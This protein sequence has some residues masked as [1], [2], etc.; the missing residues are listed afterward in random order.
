[1]TDLDKMRA[2]GT[3]A[4][5]TLD[6]IRPYIVSG[7]TTGE[8]NELCYQFTLDNDAI[9]APLGYKSYPKSVCISVNHV[10]CHGIPGDKKLKNGDILNIDVTPIL[11]GWHGDTSRM[12]HVGKPSIKAN[13]LITATYDAMMY[14]IRVIKPGA[15]IGDIGHAI[16]SSIAKTRFSVVTDYCGHG[17]GKVFH[18]LQQVLNEGVPGEGMVRTEGMYITVEPMV[19]LGKPDT[20]KSSDCWAVVT[21]DKNLSAQWE[22]TIAVVKDGYEI[23]TL[24]ELDI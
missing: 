12:F 19:N 15:T 11:D 7:I 20:N 8:L 9:P 22:H 16:S 21:K 24:S 5:R 18:E 3:L 4:S 2:A 13:N 10:I 6:F 1:M 23:L 17:I 14:G